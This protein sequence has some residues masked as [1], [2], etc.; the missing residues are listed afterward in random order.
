MQTSPTPPDSMKHLDILIHGAVQGVGFRPFVYRL[1]QEFKLS[2]WVLNSNSGLAIAAEGKTTALETFLARLQQ[3]P[4]PNAIIRNL[5]WSY[6]TWEGFADFVIR[7][8]DSGGGKTV[9]VLPDLAAC[10][11]CLREVFDPADRRYQYPFTN[12][13]HCGPR[14]SIIEALPY[15]RAYTTM[16]NFA[17]CPG[18]RREYEDPADRR[19]HAQPNACPACGPQLSLW[20][21]AGRSLA[22]RHEALCRAAQAIAAGRIVALKG[23][24]G[25]LL[26]CDARSPEAVRE[27]RRRKKRAEKPLALLF[28][29]LDSAR[30]ACQISPAEEQLLLSP[31]APIV[32][33][34]RRAENGA[35][36]CEAV[37]P[38]NPWLGVMLPYTPLH[39]LLMRELDFPII[40]TSGNLSEEPICVDECEALARLHVI[41]DLFLVHNRPIARHMD[42]SVARVVRGKKFLLRG[43]RGYAPLTV[44]LAAGKISAP[45]LAVGGHL[46]NTAAVGTG[47]AVF[48]SQHIGDL[49]S[50]IAYNA[51]LNATKSLQNLYSVQPA[52]VAC[53]L[54]PDYLSTQWAQSAA[55]QVVSVQHHHA[56]VAA[57]LA[58][59]E[60]AGPVLGVV[61]DGSGYGPDGSL[62]GGEFLLADLKGYKRLAAL[63]SFRLPGGE[64]AVR[65]PRRSA[66]GALYELFGAELPRDLA[67]WKSFSAEEARVLPAMLAKGLNAPRTTSA[68]R[69]F[70]AV[71]AL[72]GLSSRA[73][74]EG[75][76]AMAL[77]FAVGAEATA[78]AYPLPL[79]TSPDGLLILDWGPLLRAVLEDIKNAQ[80][81]AR[82]AA[83]FHNALVEGILAVAQKAAQREVVLSGGCFQNCCLLERAA[84][85]LEKEGFKPYWPQLVPCNDGG[86]SL[87]QAAVAAALDPS[88]G[89]NVPSV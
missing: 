78:E 55:A 67:F 28:P 25:F 87:G 22:E 4:P 77:E 18:C 30:A 74:F 71:S 24:G 36:I 85:R 73:G 10:P 63:R 47:A 88:A 20:D 89:P 19:F 14:F 5:S 75:Q 51:F 33:L 38:G 9:Q 21:Q 32:L 79:T 66:L 59:H 6:G 48:I 81:V 42:D 54:H 1:A 31:A 70:D 37:A 68:G 50:Q 52:R 83:R 34:K 53:D 26:A 58:E 65:E 39:A 72:A 8:S 35:R 84:E 23:L 56:H 3:Q 76:A 49:E 13:T 86:I 2:G 45:L 43:G 82:L 27:L 29:G 69:L 57:C 44:P 16:R 61:W 12:C 62:W 40:A 11:E 15:D 7:H 80:P 64:R 41:A 46:K 60:L 17:M